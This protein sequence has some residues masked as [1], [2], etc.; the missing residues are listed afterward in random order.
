MTVEAR[1]WF[2]YVVR[3]GD[4]T[5]YTGVTVDVARRVR[6]H[7]AGKGSAYTAARRPVSLVAV[8]GFEGQA[9]ALRAERAF[10]RLSRQRKLDIIGNKKSFCGADMLS[11]ETFR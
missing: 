5:L 4:E 6:D 7:N 10:K 3:C 9:A 8:W 2:L 11:R 1:P